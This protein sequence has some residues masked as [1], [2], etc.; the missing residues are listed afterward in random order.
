MTPK[1]L[2][3]LAGTSA[4]ID[5]H[6]NEIRERCGETTLLQFQALKR[7]IDSHV[8]DFVKA[9]NAAPAAVAPAKT[10]PAKKTASRGR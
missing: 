3:L 8:D 1:T 4:R 6:T 10:T 7:D 5:A 9:G 2:A